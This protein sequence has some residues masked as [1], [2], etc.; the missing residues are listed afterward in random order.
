MDLLFYA[1]VE[2]CWNPNS[3]GFLVHSIINFSDMYLKH[4]HKQL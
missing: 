1:D 4:V 2:P 3:V